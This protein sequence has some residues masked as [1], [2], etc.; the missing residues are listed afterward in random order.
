[1]MINY[2]FTSLPREHGLLALKSLVRPIHQCHA[3]EESEVLFHIMLREQ[4]T[5]HSNGTKYCS[6]GT[7]SGSEQ[8]QVSYLVHI[9][10]SSHPVAF[11]AL[12]SH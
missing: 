11:L 8:L 4:T 5:L 7:L 3:A 9:S 2:I 10:Y 6:Y 12:R 1:M